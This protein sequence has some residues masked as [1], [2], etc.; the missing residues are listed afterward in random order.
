MSPSDRRS[1]VMAKMQ[2]WIENGVEL[3]WM[4]DPDNRTVTIYRP[5]REPEELVNPEFVEGEG[6]VEGFHL[7]LT[8]I[9]EG[10]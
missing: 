4:I 8:E 1:K 3:A 9:W 5:G 2:E 6:P 10:I 7:E